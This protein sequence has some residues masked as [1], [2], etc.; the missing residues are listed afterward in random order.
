MRPLSQI[1][2]T[3]LLILFI[4]NA[5][6]A[7]Q[8]R[9]EPQECRVVC[10]GTY[11]A[12]PFDD[13]AILTGNGAGVLRFYSPFFPRHSREVSIQSRLSSG[14]P[15]KEEL[16]RRWTSEAESFIRKTG[17]QAEPMKCWGAPNWK[18]LLPENGGPRVTTKEFSDRD[19]ARMY[20]WWNAELVD[21]RAAPRRGWDLLSNPVS[22]RAVYTL[23][24]YSS[25]YHLGE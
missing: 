5:A 14:Q 17:A 22:G 25:G 18:I 23:R 21:F 2:L 12:V 13:F 10:Y 4:A 19:R 8:Y 9:A 15:F 7:D 24:L 3:V 6:R 11:L 1:F 16:V 20:R